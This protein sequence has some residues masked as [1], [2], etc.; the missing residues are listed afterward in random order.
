MKKQK[1][2]ATLLS[3]ALIISAFSMN[4]FATRIVGNSD[5]VITDGVDTFEPT[6][7]SPADITLNITGGVQNRYAVDIEYGTLEFTFDMGLVWDVN[8]H[9]YVAQGGEADNTP[10]NISTDITIVNHSDLPVYQ[11]INV[12]AKNGCDLTTDF[13]ANEANQLKK[14]NMTQPNASEANSQSTN[15]Q[16]SVQPADSGTWSDVINNN[17]TTVGDSVKLVVATIEVT[18][19]KDST[20]AGA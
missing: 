4:S 12:T 10:K 17:F 1:I 7:S 9:K 5:G 11:K 3:S 19:S 14:I 20:S 2:W 8:Q 16:F 15:V 18:I 6:N 13:S